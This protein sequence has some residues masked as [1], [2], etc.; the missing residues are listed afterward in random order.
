M[1]KGSACSKSSGFDWKEAVLL[2]FQGCWCMIGYTD[3]LMVARALT[4]RGTCIHT[5]SCWHAWLGSLGSCCCC[6]CCCQVGIGRPT[7]SSGSTEE[8]KAPTR[9]FLSLLVVPRPHPCCPPAPPPHQ[10][11]LLLL[12]QTT[13]RPPLLFNPP[14]T[15][16]TT[17]TATARGRWGITLTTLPG[18]RSRPRPPRARSQCAEC[19]IRWI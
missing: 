1:T 10:H 19:W 18:S 5:P 6:C 8:K 15:I 9:V 11:T 2:L 16:T 4:S 12:P 13:L 14:T 17:T 7:P 3:G